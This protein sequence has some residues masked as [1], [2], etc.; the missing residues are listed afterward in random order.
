M[1]QTV[2]GPISASDL[3]VTMCHEH[4]A[5]DLAG[6]RRDA[7]SVFGDSELIRSEIRRA[8]D[9]GV[10]S[11][12]EVSCADIGRDP[13]ALRDIATAL[14][15][16][17]VCST[18][19][20]LDAYH[21]EWVKK[22]SVEQ[23]EEFFLRDFDEGIDGTGVKPGVIGE[24]AGE[25]D[26]ITPSERRV[27]TASGRAAAHVGCAVTTHCQ[28]GR[29]ALEQADIL[30][31]EG[32]RAEKIVLGHL[33]LADDLDYYERI[34]ST[35]VNIGFDTCGKVAYLPD[36]RRVANLVELVK[37]GHA[38][39]IM[40]STD[41]SRKSYMTRN[42]GYGY[43]RVM[44]YFVPELRSAGI[45]QADIDRMLVHNPARVFDIEV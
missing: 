30:L 22:A 1:I 42:G 23:L 26:S 16:H 8:R 19:F 4:L 39:Q 24:V 9:A 28:M 13:R 29:M 5:V 25:Q 2:C 21:P 27:I 12:I 31:S 43:A 33:D 7:D 41:I 37:R 18:G 38:G 32:M 11:F 34:L 20:Y 17:I 10:K 14:D 45:E 44:D 15:I 36:E 40:L 3:G 6:V 35:G